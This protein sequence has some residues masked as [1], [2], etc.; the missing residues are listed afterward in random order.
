MKRFGFLIGILLMVL[1][2]DTRGQISVDEF[3]KN[4][5]QFKI[6]DWRY[7][8]SENFDIYFYDGG[9]EIAKQAAQY[10]EEEF[11][12][13]TDLLGYSPY[14]K[15]RIFLYNSVSDLQQSNVG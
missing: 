13:I 5:L 9:N 10:L 3:G 11:E 8:S 12:R 7:L 15:T 2:L 6:F 14:T 4:R 1:V